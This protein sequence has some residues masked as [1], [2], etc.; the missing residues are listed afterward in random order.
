MSN[1]VDFA[2]FRTKHAN[3]KIV[4][5]LLE[6]GMTN[7]DVTLVAAAAARAFT[8]PRPTD[9]QVGEIGL[10]CL[11]YIHVKV[12]D[13]ED[14][15]IYSIGAS[16]RTTLPLGRGHYRK[17]VIWHEDD[18]EGEAVNLSNEQDPGRFAV[19]RVLEMYDRLGYD[20]MSH[21]GHLALEA[22][23]WACQAGYSPLHLQLNHKYN[24]AGMLLHDTTAKCDVVILGHLDVWVPNKRDWEVEAD[25][26]LLSKET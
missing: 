7:S 11:K 21:Y 19:L 3:D 2:D 22:F 17:G 24:I 25:R 16:D 18:L 14:A 4:R 1:V 12:H 20:A 6:Y 9:Q 8:D 5:K 10:K 26:V 15:T 23:F 13:E